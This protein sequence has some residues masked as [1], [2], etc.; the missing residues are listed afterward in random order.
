MVSNAAYA[1]AIRHLYDDGMSVEEIYKNLDYPASIET[2][3]AVIHE[4]EAKKKSADT[5]YEYVQHQD[6]YGRSSFIKV[7]RR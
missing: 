7:K 6:K 5:E 2:I 1:D 3:E 4:Y